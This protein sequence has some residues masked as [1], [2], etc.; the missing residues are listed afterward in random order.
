[1]WKFGEVSRRSLLRGSGALI[2]LPFLEA[3]LPRRAW[4]ATASPLRFMGW[5]HANGANADMWKP[6]TGEGALGVLPPTLAALES[7]KS[8]LL[9]FSTLKTGPDTMGSHEIGL[10]ALLTATDA[11]I[12]GVDSVDQIIARKSASAVRFPSIQLAVENNGYY[13]PFTA[14]N[15]YKQ[16]S[17]GNT[18]TEDFC[19][20]SGCRSSVVGG[21]LLPNIYNPRVVFEK[22]FG[23]GTT[24]GTDPAL[25]K[26]LRYRTS[27]L[28]AVQEH[29]KTLSG[30]LGKSDQARLDEYLT[31]IRQIEQGVTKL[32][33]GP[34]LGCVAA[35]KPAGIPVDNGAHAKLLADMVVKAF[36]C[37]ATRSVTFML[38]MVVSP[39]PFIVDSITYSHHGDAS[40][41][42]GDLVKKHAKDQ[43]DLWQVSQFAYLANQLKQIPEGDGTLLD[44]CALFYSSDIADPNLHDHKNVITLLAG[45]AG[46]AFRTGRHLST[47]VAGRSTGDLF[48]S[49]LKAF[50][51]P[52]ATFN[53]FGVA[54]LDLA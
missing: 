4:A 39:M 12:P 38:G 53:K 54:A 31:G 23:T 5:F 19:T 50:G 35:G 48:L 36:Q 26:R 41:W 24:T 18:D 11:L 8:D 45:K 42:E 46:G 29:A 32:E 14:V 3:M 22:L 13:D 21:T 27:V 37:D 30:K 51:A 52:Q 49:V 47:S 15:G 10:K 7:V 1:M 9:V 20:D 33:S 6:T 43:I 28:D 16:Y 17:N 34:A 40:H 2:A 25:Q 44:H